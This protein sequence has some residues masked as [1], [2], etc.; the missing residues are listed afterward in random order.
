M[1]P[2]GV[3]C[4]RA[5]RRGTAL[6]L[7]LA[8]ACA[9]SAIAAAWGCN[10]AEPAVD[11][12]VRV[13][14]VPGGQPV[15]NL[16]N[17]RLTPPPSRFE[18]Q[19]AE[20]LFGAAPAAGPGL[21]KPV[22]LIADA[23]GVRVSDGGHAGVLALG[24]AGD[25]L[26]GVTLQPP[27]TAPA[28]L[29]RAPDG[30]LLVA[31]VG[32]AC[33]W[34]YAGDGRLR[35]RYA[36]PADVPFKPAGIACVAEEVWVSNS[37]AHRIE[38][39]AAGGVWRRAIGRRGRG[40]AEFSVPLGITRDAAGN[41][42]VV[43]MFN[44]RVQVL[45]A[46]GRWVRDIGGPGEQPG[47][48]ARPKAVAVG[49]DGVVFVSDAASQCVHAFDERGRVL[50]AF[51]GAADGEDAL[52]M[53]AG[54]AVMPGRVSTNRAPPESFSAGYAV[55]VVEQMARPGVRVF[56]WRGV[57]EALPASPAWLVPRGKK[58]AT[59]DS[60]HWRADGCRQCHAVDTAGGLAPI[61]ADRVDALCVSCH[62]GVRA[63]AESHPVGWPAEGPRTRA[64]AGWPL[65]EGRIGCLTCH[66]MRGHCSEP[67]RRPAENPGLLRGYDAAAPLDFCTRCHVAE[68]WRINP[69]AGDPV[70]GQRRDA[71][72]GACHD[73]TPELRD[74]QRRGGGG[75]RQ[76]TTALCLNCH[77]MHADPAPHGH[78]GVAT[79]A[80]RS[81]DLLP[82]EDGRIT[83]AT[84]HNPHAPG[85]FPDGTP[86]EA[87]AAAEAD[88]AVGLRLDYADL[89]RDCHPK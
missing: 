86:L 75:L 51:G 69:H 37:A 72:C 8:G 87:R 12:R 2:R 6:R 46:D 42:L 35:L 26:R 85:V 89:C 40:P 23:A 24:S 44:R 29:H 55:L 49:P 71:L 9:A 5:R 79:D 70:V 22:D 18:V 67:A 45:D 33:V 13:A 62:D 36:P 56:A 57:P 11:R 7:G 54:L 31:D 34:R 50:L 52:A 27:P 38:V 15:V 21:I 83:C 1:K 88:A 10:R 66:D 53:P 41:V 78:L 84:C 65:V 58:P 20:F 77:A 61:A 73:A 81:R 28:G 39:F 48:F 25:Y 74:G 64:V 19:L 17:L 14:D 60:P 47:R 80:L 4:G 43:D 3:R 16:G 68:Q 30:D 59:V 63:S 82:L 32:A 76:E